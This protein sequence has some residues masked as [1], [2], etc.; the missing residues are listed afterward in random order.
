L[1][2]RA[3]PRAKPVADVFTKSKRSQ[4]MAAIR[5]SG[6]KATEA[7]LAAMLRRARITG[8]RRHLPITGRPDFAF[9]A[10]RVAVFVDGCYWHGCA[11]HYRLPAGNRPYWLQ[12]L[13]R[14]RQRDREVTRA[15][16]GDGWRVVRFWEH[17]LRH[18]ER[19]LRRLSRILE[20]RRRR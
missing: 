7:R 13:E 17:D 8:W 4:V 11:R 19:V 14:N 12:K 20:Q 15:L 9:R 18:E 16:R 5:S 6:N 2:S 3:I 1:P 10:E